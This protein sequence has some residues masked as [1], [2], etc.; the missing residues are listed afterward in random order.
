MG[1]SS[2]CFHVPE[3]LSPRLSCNVASQWFLGTSRVA[4]D[5][6]RL[7]LRSVPPTSPSSN[8]AFTCSGVSN[9][10]SWLPPNADF[11]ANFSSRSF[12]IAV[13]TISFARTT[14]IAVNFSV[15][16]SWISKS[17][18]WM[19][20]KYPAAS[21]HPTACH[22]PLGSWCCMFAQWC[23]LLRVIFSSCLRP[24]Y[25]QTTVET[26]IAPPWVSVSYHP[27]QLSVEW[28]RHETTRIQEIRPPQYCGCLVLCLV[29]R[30]LT[31][32]LL[33]RFSSSWSV[34]QLVS[35]VPVTA[36]SF[37]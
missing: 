30:W 21:L 37:P 36:R 4:M 35:F 26:L 20:S 18:L 14:L 23:T 31:S 13:L 1:P 22:V 19:S 8:S 17:V 24:L 29:A 15:L 2:D 33:G 7:V 12:L 10:L 3:L 25:S 28:A 9:Q 5:V 27:L 6:L 32:D 34:P 11:Q 16:G